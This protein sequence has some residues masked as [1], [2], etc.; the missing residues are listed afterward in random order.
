MHVWHEVFL[1][2]ASDTQTSDSAIAAYRLAQD[3]ENAV[4][5]TL[6]CQSKKQH[7]PTLPREGVRRST[8]LQQ[9]RERSFKLRKL[10][11]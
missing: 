11:L 7:R 4:P 3:A 10:R 9:L 5:R 6:R 1:N 2:N 8:R